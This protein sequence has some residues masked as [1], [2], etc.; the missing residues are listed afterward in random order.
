MKIL[1]SSSHPMPMENLFGWT[2][3]HF[4]LFFFSN[5][6]LRLS[7]H[8][9]GS[10]CSSLE[11]DWVTLDFVVFV[12][13]QPLKQL[14]KLGLV[15]F[16]AVSNIVIRTKVSSLSHLKTLQLCRATLLTPNSSRKAWIPA[17][18]PCGHP[19]KLLRS[20]FV[21]RGTILMIHILLHWLQETLHFLSYSV[22]HRIF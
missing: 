19:G 17:V 15:C 5:I 22:W 18:A 10:V 20:L 7:R 6:H 2:K 21:R 12:A 9:L 1:S 16:I 4:V 11:F 8:W 14:L 13:F 3:L